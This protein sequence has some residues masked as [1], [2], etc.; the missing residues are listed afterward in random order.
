[1]SFEQRYLSA[2]GR[3]VRFEFMPGRLVIPHDDGESG[4][5]LTFE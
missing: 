3:A 5:R 2:L 4:G 1:M